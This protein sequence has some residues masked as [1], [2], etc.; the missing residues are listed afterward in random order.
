M[1][2]NFKIDPPLQKAL[3]R[4]QKSLDGDLAFDNLSRTI[5]ATD[6]SVYR[7]IPLAVA[8]PKNKTDIQKLIGFAHDHRTS[9]IPR[10]AGTSLAGQ[11]VGNG[12]VADVSRYMNQ[13]LEVNEA[14]SWVRVQP[15]VVRDALNIHLRP[16]NLFFGPNTSTANRAMIGGMVGNNSCGSYSIVYGTTRDHTLEI[17]A[18]LS[19]GSEVHFQAVDKATF[20]R[21]AIGNS[22]ENGIYRHISHEL[23]H[24][25]IQRNIREEFPKP[26]IH[27]R[28]TGYAV[29]ELLK[30][31]AFS[32]EGDDFNFC[33]L[34]SGSE[35]TLAFITEI[36]IHV[37][38]LPPV[39]TGLLC[40]HYTSVDEALRAVLVAMKYQPRAVELMDK[41]VMDCTKDNIEQQKNRFFI[42]GDPA[43]I[44]MIEVGGKSK[45]DVQQQARKIEEAMKA[46]NLGYHFPLLHSPET[47]KAWTLRKAGL[48]L[49]ANIPGDEKAVTVIEDTAVTIEDLPAYIKE[50]AA[51]MDRYQQQAVYYAHA[52]AGELHLR[53][54]LN[55]K[56]P[57][58]V[59]LFRKIGAETAELVKKYRGSLSGEHGDGRVRA[60]FIPLMVGEKN[61]Q[62][63]QRIKQTWDPKNIFNPGKI[64]DAPPMDES[65][66]Y[67]PGKATPTFDTVFDFSGNGGILRAAEKCNGSGDCRKLPLSGGTMCPSYMATRNERDT[68]RARANTLREFLTQ[69]DK[70][71]RFDHEELKEVMDL[72]LS[73]KGCTSECPSNVDMSTLKAEFTHHY[74]QA[75]GIPRRAKFFGHFSQYIKWATL[76]PSVSNALM[77]TAL[78]APFKKLMGI[79]AQR[80]LPSV[81]KTTLRKWYR[82]HGQKKQPSRA[83]KTVYLFCD[84][85]TN[86]NDTL[87]GIKAIELLQGLGY[88]VEMPDC[89]DSGRT[90]LSKGLLVEAQ[91][92][93]T[94]N[95]EVFAPLVSEETPLIGIEPS[96]IL[97]FRDEYARLVPQNMQASAKTLG[98]SC[99]LI[100]EFLWQEVELGNITPA[101]FHTETKQIVVHGHCHQKA[102][103]SVDY[104]AWLLGLPT[105][106]SVQLIPSG[107][108]GMAGSFGYEAE[109]YDISMQIGELVLFPA[110]RKAAQEVL[111][112]AP[113]TSCRHQIADGTG[114]KAVHP[115][116]VLWEGMREG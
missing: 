97:G 76:L 58:D 80:T 23:N 26:D 35:G 43:A 71:N 66:R 63:F 69:S 104:T 112:V 54:I 68:T 1:P 111:V 94:K 40:V 30:S 102:L 109:H 4:L 57:A 37:D 114:R 6:A 90:Y 75:N 67:E 116:E 78:S 29:D 11:C 51:M 56:D 41:I 87:I 98:K 12:I 96:A 24:P 16:K 55:L 108:C 46:A 100:E 36:K 59:V 2:T 18:I 113:G 73:C 89:A 84:E 8:F 77:N 48:G 3:Q 25:E 7:E 47:K 81:Y 60:E 82:K 52:G 33:K 5:Y 70:A 83:K 62:L 88:A 27:R 107:C 15:G 49:L 101:N 45:E 38:P 39:Y 74:Y 42:E 17:K 9:L 115:V 28:N 34:L 21:K 20:R 32:Y 61:Y 31:N 92:V 44:L 65:L 103:S 106:Y 13:I 22:L 79:A 95:V 72:C 19:D 99:F 14:E 105:N 53:P 64:V 110:V 50:V 93:V 10:T 85:F 86:Y 91:K